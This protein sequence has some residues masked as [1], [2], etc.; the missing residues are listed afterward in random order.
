M[1]PLDMALIEAHAQGDG[2][3]LTRLYTEAADAT[4]DPRAA[5]FFLT[6]AYVFALETGHPD[7]ADLRARLVAMGCENTD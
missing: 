2:L 3:R 7:A 6:H 1:N 5:S 4:S